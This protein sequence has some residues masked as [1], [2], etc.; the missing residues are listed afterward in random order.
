MINT[1]ISDV[2]VYAVKQSVLLSF[3]PTIDILTY[4]IYDMD[5]WKL[6]ARTV[7]RLEEEPNVFVSLLLHKNA[8]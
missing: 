2:D 5:D 6:K 8:L 4:W 3:C 1:Y 7:V